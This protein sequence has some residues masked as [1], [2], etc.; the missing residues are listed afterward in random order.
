MLKPT[1]LNNLSVL[2]EALG[3]DPARLAVGRLTV[4]GVVARAGERSGLSLQSRLR[5]KYV[6]NLFK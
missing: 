4:V 6:D 3:N 5:Q 1:F 2:F